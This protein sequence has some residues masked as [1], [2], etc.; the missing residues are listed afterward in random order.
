MRVVFDARAGAAGEVARPATAAGPQL[1]RPVQVRHHGGQRRRADVRHGREA[2]RP[3]AAA[4]VL[5][6]GLR[7]SMVVV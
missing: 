6:M 5:R 7:G 2:V 4:A 3:G 1:G